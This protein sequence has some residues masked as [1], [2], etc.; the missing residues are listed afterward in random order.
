[1]PPCTA[2]DV[3]QQKQPIGDLSRIDW[4]AW[5]EVDPGRAGGG[6]AS[7]FCYNLEY[8]D[9]RIWVRIEK[10]AGWELSERFKTHH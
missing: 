9:K 6:K 7:Q 10:S 1:M 5:E 2:E 3:G 4:E 8:K